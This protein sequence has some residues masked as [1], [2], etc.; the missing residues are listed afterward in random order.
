MP[1][2]CRSLNRFIKRSSVGAS[3]R[4]GEAE[5]PVDA[6]I[7]GKRGSSGS[8]VQTLG[9]MLAVADPA[10]PV[11]AHKSAPVSAKALKMLK[12][13]DAQMGLG[14]RVLGPFRFGRLPGRR[15]L[16]R[17]DGMQGRQDGGLIFLLDHSMVLEGWDN[18]MD[19]RKTVAIIGAGPVGLAA[20]AH[21][22][23]RGM[24][25]VVLEA[26]PEAG[27]SVR[28]WQQVQLMVAPRSAP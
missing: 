28:Q 3:F 12:R 20:A 5:N 19:A 11:N 7:F 4:P 9:C 15:V 26:G 1:L 8:P 22:L 24:T 25:P 21:V 27:H 13:P 16:R 23:E 14:W 10:A 6:Q 17:R 2:L 18:P